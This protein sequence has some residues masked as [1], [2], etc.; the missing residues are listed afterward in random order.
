METIRVD[1]SNR[2][3]AFFISSNDVRGLWLWGTDADEIFQSII[4]T[5][6]AL[7]E[8]NEGIIVDIREAEPGRTRAER[9]FSQDKICQT[10]D[11]FKIGSAERHATV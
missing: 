6:K 11:V 1:I 9:W 7:Y 5:L 3:G 10:F 8:Y 2:N 4:P